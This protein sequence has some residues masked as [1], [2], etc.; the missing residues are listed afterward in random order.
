MPS[1]KL[2]DLPSHQTLLDL[3]DLTYAST[4]HYKEMAPEAR[5]LLP[6]ARIYIGQNERRKTLVNFTLHM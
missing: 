1:T 6:L 3:D 2:N 4:D 5:P